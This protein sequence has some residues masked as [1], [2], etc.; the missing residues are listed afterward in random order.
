VSGDELARF[1]RTNRPS[2]ARLEALL[3][4]A[5]D[6]RVTLAELHE[7]D[8]AWR[9]TVS[10]LARARARHPGSEV[11]RQLDALVARAY[12]SLYRPPRS[13]RERLSAFFAREVPLAFAALSRFVGGAALLLLAG[14]A[15][16]AIAVT[17][18]ETIVESLVPPALISGVRQG[19]MWTDDLLTVAPA[20][21]VSTKILTNNVAVTLLAFGLGL[22]LGLPTAL[23]LFFNGF[24]VGAMGAL[25]A[26]YGLFGRFF[27]FLLSHGLLEL[28]LV[29]VAG[30]AGLALGGALLAPGDRPRREVL[31]ERLRQGTALVVGSAPAMVLL[32]FVEG[33]VSPGEL[34]PTWLKALVGV[35][36]LGLYL[37][38]LRTFAARA[39]ATTGSRAGTTTTGRGPEL[40]GRG[41]TETQGRGPDATARADDAR[42]AEAR[43]RSQAVT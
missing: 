15:A 38:W 33:Y 19:R 39:A 32:G 40:G 22:A 7:L 5:R 25:T 30:G 13:S 23:V 16:G 9:R 14:A 2:W 18:D 29:A 37:G 43:T 10:D 41:G 4:L 12:A 24:L 20:A 27:D 6:G 26:K 42:S 11:E 31:A 21:V 28:T 3:V 35:T 1:I 34:F 8:R 17:A 36:L